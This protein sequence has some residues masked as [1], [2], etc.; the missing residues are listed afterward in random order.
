MDRFDFMRSAINRLGAGVEIGPLHNAICPKRDG[1]NTLVMDAF[2]GE[3]LRSQ[4]RNDPNVDVGLVE[5]VDIVYAGSFRDSVESFLLNSSNN[6][7]NSLESLSYIISSHNFEHQPNPIQF[8][9]DCE[10]CLR[11]GGVLVMAIPIASRCF[12][13]WLPLTTTGMA[14]D[15]FFSASAKPSIGAI[16]DS[17]KTQASLSN[18]LPLHDQSYDINQVQLEASFDK[19]WLKTLISDHRNQYVDAHVSRFNSFSF[20]LLFKESLRLGLLKNL[21]LSCSVVNGAEFLVVIKK[22][23]TANDANQSLSAEQRTDLFKKAVLFHSSDV[24]KG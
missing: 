13:C 3:Q 2:T 9:S 5:D 17:L 15:A 18:G 10:H 12:D 11:P 6:A 22:D 24:A 21:D 4:Y 14:L 16:F 19:D 8:L 20:E 23:Y 7:C 1:W